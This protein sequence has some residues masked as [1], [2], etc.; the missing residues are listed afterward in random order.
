MRVARNYLV[1]SQAGPSHLAVKVELE[2][3][4]RLLPVAVVCVCPLTFS[5]STASNCTFAST[6]MSFSSQSIRTSALLLVEDTTVCWQDFRSSPNE[7]P[8][9]SCSCVKQCLD[10][11]GFRRL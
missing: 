4:V 10:T 1:A 11:I 9:S 3:M 2:F 8:L 6:F 5:E 7:A